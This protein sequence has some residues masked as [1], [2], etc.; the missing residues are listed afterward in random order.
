MSSEQPGGAA[1]DGKRQWSTPEV[2]ALGVFSAVGLAG[3]AATFMLIVARGPDSQDPA[4]KPLTA[5]DMPRDA[6]GQPGPRGERGPPGQPGPRGAA[7]DAGVRILRSDCD[8]GNC[9]VACDNDEVL[10]TAHCGVGRAQAIYPTEHTALCRSPG[11]RARVEVV[12]ACVK[13]SRQ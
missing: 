1:P 6:V 8:T 3:F 7:G 13:A 5:A 9:T 11:G 10:L 2:W 12:A 4:S